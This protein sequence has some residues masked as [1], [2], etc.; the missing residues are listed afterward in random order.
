M[1]DIINLRQARKEKKRREQDVQ[2]AANR[3]LFGRTKA[4]K[5][6]DRNKSDQERK[7]I[8]GKRLDGEGE[9]QR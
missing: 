4:E 1:A 6:H 9:D 5:K 2:A 8:E 7:A 3:Q